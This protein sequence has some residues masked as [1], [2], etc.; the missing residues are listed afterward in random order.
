MTPRKT[1][2]G[3]TPETPSKTPN[4]RP[5]L[6]GGV[7]LS[8]NPGNKGGGRPPKAFKQFLADLRQ[9]PRV[10]LAIEKAAT[11]ADAKNFKAALDV[12]VRYDIEKPAEQVDVNHI[13]PEQ[14]EQAV[15]GILST[16]KKRKERGLVS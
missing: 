2:R 10:Q 11:D 7:L 14:R 13:G 3:K 6:H 12:I 1:R 4:V 15:L 5:G 8:G 9:D 16:A